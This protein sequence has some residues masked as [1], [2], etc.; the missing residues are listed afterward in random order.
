LKKLRRNYF[1]QKDFDTTKNTLDTTMGWYHTAG[2]DFEADGE[3]A[4]AC[5]IQRSAGEEAP[6]PAPA[7]APAAASGTTACPLPPSSA[8]PPPPPDAESIYHLCQKS[9]W[10]EAKARQEPY[11]PPTFVADGKFTRAS[12]NKEDLVS[13]ANTYYRESDGDWIVLEINCKMLYGLGIAILAQEEAPESTPKQPVKCLQVFGGISTTLPGLITN[14]YKMKRVPSGTF[15]SISS[16]GSMEP[17]KMA[18][19]TTAVEEKKEVA[20]VITPEKKTRQKSW[21]FWPKLK[22]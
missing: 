18:T 14:V 19:T 16:T 22:K 17:K 10:R 2:F 15:I 13:T 12:V 1:I 6:A 11:F 8:P 21:R 7:P 5:P 20:P 3:A 9:K 4:P